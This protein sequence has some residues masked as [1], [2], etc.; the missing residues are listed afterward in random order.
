[1]LDVPID[2]HWS[3][4]R[5]GRYQNEHDIGA[6]DIAVK[7]AEFNIVSYAGLNFL[8]ISGFRTL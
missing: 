6:S 1:M 4:V 8:P 3:V 2:G 5:D 7:K